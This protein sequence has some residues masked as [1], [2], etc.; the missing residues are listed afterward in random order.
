MSRVKAVASAIFFASFASASAFADDAAK[1][2]PSAA[3]VN[4]A[5]QVSPGDSWTYEV[6]DD[7]TGDLLSTA[8]FVATKVTADGIETRVD[9][10]Q[11]ITNAKTTTT[12][13][14]DTR[15][16]LKD[17]GNVVFRPYS[18]NSG[19]PA[20]LQVGKSWSFKYQSLRKGAALT[21]QFTGAGKVEAWERVTLPNGS[22][23][24]AFKIDVT[25]SASS[26]RKR[27]AHSTTWFSPAV[28]RVIKRID[29]SRENG[30]LRDATEQI[31]REYKPAPKT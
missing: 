12:E 30:K 15:W 13:I 17:N 25:L 6:R 21:E 9:R 8:T 20:D 26:G 1:T 24:D 29:E 3:P 10:E 28:N 18:D 19:A 11:R 27:E 5:I 7:V 4:P 31:L 14:F 22:A 2:E 23:Y 16:R